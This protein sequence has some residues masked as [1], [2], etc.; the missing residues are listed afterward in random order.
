M[1]SFPVCKTFLRAQRG[2]YITKSIVIKLTCR[3]KQSGFDEKRLLT[4]WG[5]CECVCV[6]AACGRCTEEADK[7]ISNLLKSVRASQSC[8]L[9]THTHAHPLRYTQIP[10]PMLYLKL[11]RKKS[12]GHSWIE[13][14]YFTPV[15]NTW[16]WLV[17]RRIQPYISDYK[18]KCCITDCLC[19]L[20]SWMCGIMYSKRDSSPKKENLL[21]IYSK[22]SS[23]SSRT[24]KKI[25]GE[26][27]VLGD[28]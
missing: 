3:L 22:S 27:V 7:G 1:S 2:F 26:T 10:Q 4:C 28:S 9:H 14:Y 25:L 6:C 11:N 8:A 19:F 13:C 5:L 20:H 24:V 15:W 23:K 16:F 18:Q 21:L 17:S 12:L